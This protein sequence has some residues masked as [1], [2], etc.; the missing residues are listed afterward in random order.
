MLGCTGYCPSDLA[1]MEGHEELGRWLAIL[2]MN[3]VQK[4]STLVK[5]PMWLTEPI[6]NLGISTRVSGKDQFT[7]ERY[8]GLRRMRST[9]KRKTYENIVVN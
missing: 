5:L 9:R 7:W 2:E 8:G 6:N 1:G 3:L 4:L